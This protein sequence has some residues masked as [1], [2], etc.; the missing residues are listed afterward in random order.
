MQH[1]PV[2]VGLCSRLVCIQSCQLVLY[3]LIRNQSLPPSALVVDLNSV[4]HP[5]F[6]ACIRVDSLF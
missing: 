6:L 5:E 1:P 3:A 2:N 4:I